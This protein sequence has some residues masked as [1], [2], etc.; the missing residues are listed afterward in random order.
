MAD[1]GGVLQAVEQAASNLAAAMAEF[2]ATGKTKH[3]GSVASVPL[4]GGK[5]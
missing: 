3:K 5:S 4:G 2:A 1:A